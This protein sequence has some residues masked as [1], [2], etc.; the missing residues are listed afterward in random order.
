MKVISRVLSGKDGV[1]EL[2]LPIKTERAKDNKRE[3][4]DGEPLCAQLNEDKLLEERLHA[5]HSAEVQA[6][7]EIT[8]ARR[9]EEARV[10][11]A[12]QAR[13]TRA[14]NEARDLKKSLDAAFNSLSE[15]AQRLERS[16][17]G[18]ALQELKAKK[19]ADQ[20]ESLKQHAA[21]GAACGACRKERWTVTHAPC[22]C[23]TCAMCASQSLAKLQCAICKK[24]LCATTVIHQRE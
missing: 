9:T 10:A 13:A 24:E 16:E 12:A 22:G 21:R 23:R 20:L 11:A 8:K 5:I 4:A 15:T 2:P 17:A 14:E 1:R 6:I 19:I 7:L 18:V 3:R